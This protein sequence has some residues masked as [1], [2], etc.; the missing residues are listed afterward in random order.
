[1]PDTARARA[2][3]LAAGALC[4]RLRGGQLE[5]LL[6]H[7]PRYDDWSWPKG[8]Q[9]DGEALPQ[10]AV[11]E[12]EEEAGV[13][14]TLG[15]ALPT[16]TYAV[17][18]G[19]KDVS[20]WAAQLHPATVAEP[21]G[22]EV[23]RVRWADPATAAR[24]LTNP[25]DRE[26]LDAL[27]TAHDAGTL[28]TR[29]VL[30]IRHAKAKPRSGWTHAEGQRPLAATGRRQAHALA[31][32]LV[33]WRPHRIVTSPWLRCTQTISPYAR[34]HD[35]K[36]VTESALTE[37]NARRKPRRAAA[38]MEKVLEKSRPMAVCTHRPVLPVVLEV[39]AAHAGAD[40][41]RQLPD[42]D[43]YLSPG[44]VLVLHVSTAEPG[45]I[46]GVERHQPFDD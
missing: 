11:R 38:A 46:V 26:P 45:R 14:I 4:W 15:I 2:V 24:L 40:L 3:V 9:D 7:R 5:V 29:E 28:A 13:R 10:T 22:K 16:A 43:P 34:K 25:T 37:A 27:V 17:A 31:G 8:K 42:A 35:V 32:L 23:D 20:Y 1:M 39:I 41:A 19:R 33:A 30:V 44:E 18:A 6:I 12:V 36:V 21:D